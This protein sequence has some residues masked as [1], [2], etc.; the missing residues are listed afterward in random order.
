MLGLQMVSVVLDII[1]LA[2]EGYLFLESPVERRRKWQ[3]GEEETLLKLEEWGRNSFHLCAAAA[4]LLQV[5]F[6]PP[7][8]SGAGAAN[9][10]CV[11]SNFRSSP[12]CGFGSKCPG[13]WLIYRH[14]NILPPD[15]LPFTASFH[16]A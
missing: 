14:T 16:A 11:T 1:A 9:Y 7:P 4:A 8:S 2:K 10:F 13:Q 5:Q 3:K 12:I 15:T 6:P